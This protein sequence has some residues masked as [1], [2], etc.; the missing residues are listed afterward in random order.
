MA[1]VGRFFCDFMTPILVVLLGGVVAYDHLVVRPT[2]ESPA[3]VVN[4]KVLGRKFAGP[5]ASAFGDAWA[6]AANTLEQGKSVN[7]A[8][9][10]LQA[11]WQD[12]RAQAFATM[13]TPEFA[14]ILP[15]GTEPATPL[16]R[17]EVVKLWRDFAAGLKGAR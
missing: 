14:K 12:G 2:A 8:Q 15:E 9:A 7:E 10:A 13:V 1:K 11:R 4:G 5:V 17:G 16:Q 6:V 3:V